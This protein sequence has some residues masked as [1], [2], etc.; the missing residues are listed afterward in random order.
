MTEK[1]IIARLARIEC[2]LS[3]ENLHCDG[4]ISIAEA[5]AKGRRLMNE[6]SK[7]EAQLGRVP[8]LH[9]LFPQFAR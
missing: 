8:T 6:K 3:P 1:Q 2:E 7:L 5:R 4:E 9:E